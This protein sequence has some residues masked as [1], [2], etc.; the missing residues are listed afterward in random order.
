M[1]QIFF[2][3]IVGPG[4]FFPPFLAITLQDHISN[5]ALTL[6]NLICIKHENIHAKDTKDTLCDIIDHVQIFTYQ[7]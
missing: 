7:S 3:R 1:I 6:P 2:L 4:R 5:P